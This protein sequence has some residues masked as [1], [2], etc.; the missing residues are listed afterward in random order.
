MVDNLCKL[1]YSERLSS[2]GLT[3]LATR[4][5]HGDLVET[6]EILTHVERIDPDQFFFLNDTGYALRGHSLKVSDSTFKSIST[7]VK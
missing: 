5:L 2:L 1:S 7:A 3:T 6:Y 4:R